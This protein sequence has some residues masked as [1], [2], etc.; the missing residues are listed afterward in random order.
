M[1]FRNIQPSQSEFGQRV[2]CIAVKTARIFYGAA[3]IKR[4]AFINPFADRVAQ[5]F[6]VIREIKIH[7][8]SLIGFD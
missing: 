7:G 3:A 6:L 5:L 2:I 1:L 8:I 4:I